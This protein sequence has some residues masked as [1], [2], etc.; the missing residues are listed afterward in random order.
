MKPK[1]I[2]LS[3]SENPNT[4]DQNAAASTT[5]WQNTRLEMKS[6]GKYI[7]ENEKWCDCSFLVGAENNQRIINGHKLIMGMASPVFERMFYGK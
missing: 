4:M 3:S 1:R 5:D 6:R 7:L 2:K